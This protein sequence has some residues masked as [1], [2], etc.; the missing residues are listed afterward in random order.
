MSSL[1]MY[2]TLGLVASNKTQFTKNRTNMER[3]RSESLFC[4]YF[5][6]YLFFSWSSQGIK[7]RTMVKILSLSC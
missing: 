3:L 6:L 7:R 5:E 1:M 4:Q 2:R